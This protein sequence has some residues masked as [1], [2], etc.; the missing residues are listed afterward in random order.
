MASFTPLSPETAADQRLY[1]DA[2]LQEVRCLDCLAR[3][4]VKKNSEF[5]TSIQWTAEAQTSCAEFNRQ[6]AEA[7][8]RMVHESCSRLK[9]SIDEAVREGRLR[10]SDGTSGTDCV[11]HVP[12]DDPAGR[13][14][15]REA[16][17]G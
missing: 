8:R 2:S 7:S 9:A 1:L 12:A 6:N 4:R 5:H 3:V 14:A 10:V 15:A 17:H 13:T 16:S 11:G